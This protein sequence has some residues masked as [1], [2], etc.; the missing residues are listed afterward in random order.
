MECPDCFELHPASYTCED[1]S[2]LSSSQRRIE[3][4][5][6]GLSV[7][8]TSEVDARI[9]AEEAEKAKG[10]A[11]DEAERKARDRERNRKA[12]ERVKAWREKNRLEYNEYMREYRQGLRRRK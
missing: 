2:S 3:L 5:R 4:A 9:A 11:E 6:A 10:R 7:E 12:A 1:W 8:D